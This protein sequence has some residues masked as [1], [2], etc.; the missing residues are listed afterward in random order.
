MQ[1]TVSQHQGR[2]PVMVIQPHGDVDASNYTELIN[3]VRKLYEEG[4]PDFL[5]DLGE[6]PF[7]S[8]AGL[9]ALHSLAMFLRGEPLAGSQPAPGGL[10]SLDRTRAGGIQ[11]HI[12][13]LGPQPFVA[14]TLDK[15]GFT[16]SF[17]V[18]SDLQKAV[19]SF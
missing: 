3:Q 5:I 18:H 11:Q 16:Q 15:A 2:V 14:E 12:K 9:V 8:S 17:E 6:V 19:A 7:M 1:I 10:K 4:A 13:L